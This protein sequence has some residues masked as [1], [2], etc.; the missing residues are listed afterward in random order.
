[1]S[2]LSA[3]AGTLMLP[4][5][6][7]LRALGVA[8]EAVGKEFEDWIAVSPVG[9]DVEDEDVGVLLIWVHDA[10]GLYVILGSVFF[11]NVVVTATE[12]IGKTGAIDVGIMLVDEDDVELVVVVRIPRMVER[13]G[14][15]V[16]VELELDEDVIEDAKACGEDVGGG[17][18][19]GGA[20]DKPPQPTGEEIK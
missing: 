16:K 1:M 9:V 19:A 7:G 3:H 12:V 8:S 10:G 13:A 17:S 2:P 15:L 18:G 14:T 20:L 11:I 6:A 5:A 4:R